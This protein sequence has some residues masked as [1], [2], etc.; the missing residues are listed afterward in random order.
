[1]NVQER[2]QKQI[3]DNP[4]ILYMKGTPD[5]PQCGF[6]ARA[7]Q[8]LEQCGADFAFVNVFEDPEVRENLKQV[9]GWPTFPQLFVRGELMGG[10]DI[11]LEMFQSG[12]LQKLV[13]EAAT[14]QDAN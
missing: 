7:V 12:E 13:A 5:F 3:A 9:S 1:M 4:V 2:I 10:S 8:I 6:S 11:M 14:Q